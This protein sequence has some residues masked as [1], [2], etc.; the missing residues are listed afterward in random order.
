MNKQVVI[1]TNVPICP[2]CNGTLRLNKIMQKY[3]CI[4]CDSRFKILNF[5][6]TEREFVCEEVKKEN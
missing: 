5:G 2:N 3:I 1:Q 6:Q 4:A